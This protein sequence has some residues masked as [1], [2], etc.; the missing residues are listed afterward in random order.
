MKRMFFVLS[1]LMLASSVMAQQGKPGEKF[2]AVFDLG[3]DFASQKAKIEADLADGKTYSELSGED[4][5]KVQ[6][7]LGN[8]QAV[9]AAAGGQLKQ[10][11]KV[12]LINDQNL[13]N[14]ILGKAAADSRVVC[15]REAVIG[16][17]RSTTNCKTVAERRRD[18]EEAQEL[19]RRSPSGTYNK[20]S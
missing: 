15:R 5:I 17:L 1:V 2:A 3:S 19:M 16:S 9:F 7:A 11:Q 14:Q 12:A 10:D 18:A 4:R 6:D 8:I 20:G 13:V